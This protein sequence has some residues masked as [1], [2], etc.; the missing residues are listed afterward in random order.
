[1]PAPLPRTVKALGFVS[2]LT[3]ASSEM[4]YPLLPSF[5]TGTLKAGP[6]FLGLIEGV[7]ETTASFFKLGSGILSDRFKARKPLVIVGYTVSSTVRPLVGLAS[8]AWHVL[9]IRFSDRVGKG[10]RSSPRDALIAA[11][12]DPSDRGRAFG[13]HRSMDHLGAV[14]GPLLASALLYSG[15]SLRGVFLIAAVPGFASIVALVRGVREEP[16]HATPGPARAG[17]GRAPL[18]AAMSRYLFVVGLFTLGNSSDAFLLLR[19]Q[20]I[21]VTT[22]AL[23]LLWSFHHVVKSSLSTLGGTLSDRLGRRGTIAIGWA[24]YAL[25][26]VGFALATRPFHAWALFAVYG[27][28]F[29]LTEGAE[30]ALVA[31]FSAP[32]NR[33]RAF[34]LFHGVVGILSLPASLITGVLW[35]RFGGATALLAGAALAAVAAALLLLAVQAPLGAR[36]DAA[37]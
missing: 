17:S 16:V 3:D 34:G 13:F 18:G 22:A 23:P 27:V 7:A 6:A 37:R 29:A 14:I 4:I 20:S 2:L 15:V 26:Y 36:G 19:A 10:I 5:V 21:G 12:T 32:E 28:F 11:V 33:G 1:M 30:R 31:D 9:A 35:Q 25:A 24:V 8:A